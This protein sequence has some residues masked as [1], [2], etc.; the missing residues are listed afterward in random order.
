MYYHSMAAHVCAG[1]ARDISPILLDKLCNNR[2]KRDFAK[3]STQRQ[4]SFGAHGMRIHTV[5]YP[6]AYRFTD[7]SLVGHF[8][9]VDRIP[10]NAFRVHRNRHR[11]LSTIQ[12][13]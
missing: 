7:H 13:S 9:L 3:E 10:P 6:S 5:P 1:P 12:P 11:A 8:L 4:V 2:C